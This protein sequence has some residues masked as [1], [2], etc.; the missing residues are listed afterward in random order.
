MKN[1][2]CDVQVIIDPPS[3]HVACIAELTTMQENSL[4]ADYMLLSNFTVND[5]YTVTKQISFTEEPGGAQFKPFARVIKLIETG[6]SLTIAY[7]GEI[8]GDIAQ[9][10]NGIYSDFILLTDYAPWFPS[11][12]THIEM[13][14]RA[15]IKAVEDFIFLNASYDDGLGCWIHEGQMLLGVRNHMIETAKYGETEFYVIYYDPDETEAAQMHTQLALKCLEFY[16]NKLLMRKM[17]SKR[18]GFVRPSH[19][20]NT[21]WGFIREGITVFGG[22]LSAQVTDAAYAIAHE[23]GHLWSIGAP[24]NWEDWLNESFAEYGAFL[25]LEKQ[26]GKTEYEFRIEKLLQV[27]KEHFA[28]ASIKPDDN[29]DRPLSVHTKGAIVLNN[30]RNAF[31]YTTVVD[32]IRCFDKLKDKSTANLLNEMKKAGMSDVAEWLYR[33]IREPF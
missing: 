17:P 26:F 10:N 3:C 32:T 6:P 19:P 14:V 5:V 4:P 16:E 12:V 9:Y 22:K 7:G 24:L 15:Q 1:A 25:F 33:R 27:N 20:I 2:R 30:M 13:G 31:G 11:P 29:N 23:M 28:N 8:R 21:G 18:I